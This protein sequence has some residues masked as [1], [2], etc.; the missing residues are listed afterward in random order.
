MNYNTCN[1]MLLVKNFTKIPMRSLDSLTS[2]MAGDGHY[3]RRNVIEGTSSL[4]DSSKIA[5]TCS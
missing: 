3:T 4:Q 2:Y 5:I 1:K